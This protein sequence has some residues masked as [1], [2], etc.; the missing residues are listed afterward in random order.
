M[1]YIPFFSSPN[2]DTFPNDCNFP[3]EYGFLHPG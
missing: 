3:A 1:G 2:V